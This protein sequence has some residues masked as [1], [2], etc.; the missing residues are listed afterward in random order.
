M[1]AVS[2]VSALSLLGLVACAHNGSTVESTTPAQQGRPQSRIPAESSIPAGPVPTFAERLADA[3]VLFVERDERPIQNAAGEEVLVET[4]AVARIGETLICRRLDGGETS[5]WRAPVAAARLLSWFSDSQGQGVFSQI[6]LDLGEPRVRVTV[7]LL[8]G[9]ELR[10]TAEN[11]SSSS[12]YVPPSPY[13]E[14]EPVQAPALFDELRGMH[15]LSSTELLLRDEEDVVYCTRDEEVHTCSAPTTLA[16]LSGRGRRIRRF[17]RLFGNLLVVNIEWA[18]QEGNVYYTGGGTEFLRIDGAELSTLAFVVYVSDSNTHTGGGGDGI[19]IS[20]VSSEVNANS[21]SCIVVEALEREHRLEREDGSGEELSLP[22]LSR[23]PE[24]VPVA[25]VDPREIS[26][27][28]AWAFEP[29]G[30]LRRIEH[31]DYEE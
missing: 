2:L 29:A 28:G 10:A 11:R 31:C 24:T 4:M 18:Y 8:Q 21:S 12:G 20:R 17:T 5:C 3:R 25:G 27:E 19:E 1:Q 14:F 6:Q 7:Q 16:G 30:G 15:V 23:A 26:M 22:R 9:G 13:E